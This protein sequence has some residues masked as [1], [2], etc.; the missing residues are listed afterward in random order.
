AKGKPDAL[1]LWGNSSALNQTSPSLKLWVGGLPHEATDDVLW[2]HFGQLQAPV[3]AEVLYPGVGCVA[4]D[5]E[6]VA[7]AARGVRMQRWRRP[8][9]PSTT[10]T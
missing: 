6:E 9:P 2:A 10:P 1:S 7:A 5:S 3:S 4:F 8:C